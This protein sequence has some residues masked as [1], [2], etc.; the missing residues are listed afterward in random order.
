MICIFLMR[1]YSFR[2]NARLCRLKTKT[3]RFETISTLQNFQLLKK[4]LSLLLLMISF[5]VARAYRIEW[6]RS[7]TISRPVYED[8]YIA[9]GTV[10]IKAPVYGDVIIAGGT[11]IISDTIL[12]DL[13]LVG[14]MVNINGYVADDIRC[15]GGELHVNSNVGG[16]LV[17]T[18][19]KVDIAK[20]VTVAGGLLSS[21]G[22]I[23]S[24]ATIV[25]DVEVSAGSF[26]FSGIVNNNLDAR[27]QT[28]V[29]NGSVQGT[30]I[31]AAPELRLGS[32]ARFN[33]NV[34]YWSKKQVPNFS[35]FLNGGTAR[36]DTSLKVSTD[37]WYYLDH[38][39]ILGL[40]WYLSAVLLF[41][42]LLQYLFQSLFIKAGDLVS[43]SML[44]SLGYGLLFFIGVPVVA[45]LLF[46]T[47]IGVPVG[48]LMIFT[49]IVLLLL[50]SVIS[51]LV[52][53]N[54]Y[55]RRFEMHWHFWQIV[56]AALPMFI[57]FKLITFTPFFGWLIMFVLVGIAFGSLLRSIQWPHKPYAAAH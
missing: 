18:G 54:W 48:A 7:V 57:L 4:A 6:G 12:N 17:I 31:L 50:A 33:S 46:I 41:L 2:V 47:V 27:C 30:A 42:I 39:T 20:N 1:G 16:D 10:T 55:N 40:I 44:R 38:S 43:Q 35:R 23:N 26:N 9:G 24:G 32:D 28:L 5:T 25:G 56:F 14:G 51:S 53:A 45:A 29:M 15:A 37:S 13:M 36:Y 34:R 22:E 49:Y 3:R 52:L 8:L 21:G 11:V 19:G